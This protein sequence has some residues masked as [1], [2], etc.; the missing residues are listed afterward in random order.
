[1]PKAISGLNDGPAAGQA[2][3]H[4]YVHLI[5]RYQG[6]MEDPTGG[7]RGVIPEKQKFIKDAP[8]SPEE[9]E[10]FQILRKND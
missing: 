9:E 1:M 2:M 8:P 5:P 10:F 7:V 6:D 3:P 4:L